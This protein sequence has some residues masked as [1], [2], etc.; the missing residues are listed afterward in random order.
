MVRDMMPAPAATPYD[1]PFARQSHC[2]RH[3]RYQ[4]R[5]HQ[6]TKVLLPPPPCRQGN[7]Q[8]DTSDYLNGA[9]ELACS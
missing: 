3:D 2:I 4:Y 6:C 9:Y 7:A 8:A 5:Y 1:M